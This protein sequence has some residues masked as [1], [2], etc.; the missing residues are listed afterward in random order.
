MPDRPKADADG[1]LPMTDETR[2]ISAVLDG[3]A[4]AFEPLIAKYEKPIFN[5][6]YRTTGSLDDAVELTQETFLKAY[7]KLDQFQLGRNFFSW[8]YALAFNIGRDYLRHKKRHPPSIHDNPGQVV[9]NQQSQEDPRLT[10]EVQSVVRA[11][12]LLPIDYREAIVL[13]F[14]EECTMQEIADMLN[15]SLSGAKMRVHRGLQKLRA[16]LGDA[17]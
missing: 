5:L 4:D 6:M 9:E 12:E 11:L 15:L 17:S 2:I 10:E 13:R 7:D 1:L 3:E 16:I 8:L 14:R